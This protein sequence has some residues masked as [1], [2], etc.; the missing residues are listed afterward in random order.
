[1]GYRALAWMV[2]GAVGLACAGP[3]DGALV[4]EP[5]RD[6]KCRDGLKCGKASFEC[7]AK[8]SCLDSTGKALDG[9]CEG[10]QICVTD[11][12]AENF[13]I[14]LPGGDCANEF[15]PE[16]VAPNVM[17]LLD[18][19]GSMN[20][21]LADDRRKWDVA[22]ETFASVLTAFEGKIRF[23]LA[24]FSSCPGNNCGDPGVVC[25]LCSVGNIKYPINDSSED[26]QAFLASSESDADNFLCRPENGNSDGDESSIGATLK[27]LADEASW[28]SAGRDHAVLLISDGEEALCEADPPLPPIAAAA[29]LSGSPSVQTHVVGFA[30]DVGSTNPEMLKAIA[31]NGG[32][33]DYLL[34]TDTSGL[35][36]ALDS[37]GSE[38]ALS[39]THTLADNVPPEGTKIYVYFDASVE[40]LPEDPVDG[41]TYDP[42]TT[43]V[44]L[45]GASCDKVKSGEVDEVVVS[46]DCD[47]GEF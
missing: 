24:V 1:M 23:G 2:I 26:I 7:M 37:V 33:G 16:R 15:R 44:T 17:I 22:K 41:W 6:K 3:G 8:D 31:E 34:A 29:L 46:Y 20:D 47:R 13:G 43:T 14:C 21:K 30:S 27:Y 38:A 39:C 9:N 5:C 45:H 25:P 32:T 4:G 18:R 36:Q 35:E 19:T 40:A 10:G 12:E 42:A 11:A 28:K